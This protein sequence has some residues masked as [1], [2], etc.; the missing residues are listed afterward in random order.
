MKKGQAGT[1]WFIL[2]MT[3]LLIAFIV[4]VPPDVRLALLS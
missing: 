3:L 2:I 4:A 1:V